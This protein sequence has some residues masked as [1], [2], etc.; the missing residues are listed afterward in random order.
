MPPQSLLDAHRLMVQALDDVNGS[1]DDLD[2]ALRAGANVNAPV[3]VP[4]PHGA[5]DVETFPLLLALL[6]DKDDAWVQRLLAAGA[7]LDR[8]DSS[9]R[10]PLVECVRRNRGSTIELLLNAGV[11]TGGEY[12]GYL[13]VVSILHLAV[14]DAPHEQA[15]RALVNGGLPIDPRDTVGDTPLHCAAWNHQVANVAILLDLGA[16]PAAQNRHG[17]TP[18]TL[19]SSISST[20][21]HEDYDAVRRLLERAEL[22]AVAPTGPVVAR[23][24]P[25]L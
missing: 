6:R 15:I 14:R 13:R 8:T 10:S 21:D 12:G 24:R 20:T 25:R 4:A 5:P 22:R 17:E 3:V 7:N 18:L 1:L 2:R 19:I 9:A 16:D 11:D 23:A